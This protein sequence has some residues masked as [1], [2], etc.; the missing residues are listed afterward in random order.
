[1][2][3]LLE[4]FFKGINYLQFLKKEN[5]AS[6]KT[7]RCMLRLLISCFAHPKPRCCT[8]SNLVY[9]CSWTEHQLQVGEI[10]CSLSPLCKHTHTPPGTLKYQSRLELSPWHFCFPYPE[11]VFKL[12][13]SHIHKSSLPTL[14]SG[15]IQQQWLGLGTVIS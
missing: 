13:K 1:M 10:T 8:I 5:H 12:G 2:P 6:F 15:R 4:F 14:R 3:H 11:K 9:F 7:A